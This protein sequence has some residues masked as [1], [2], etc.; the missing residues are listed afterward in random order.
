MM[1]GAVC[2]TSGNETVE[3]VDDLSVEDPGPGEVRVKIHS[4]G[5]CHSD[6][7]GMNGNLPQGAP[8]VPGHEGAGEVVAVGEGVTSTKVGDH[9]IVAWTPPCGKCAAC[10][11]GQPNLCVDI[12]FAIAGVPHFKRAGDDVFG[13]AGTG[14]WVEELI[15][16]EQ[17]VVV[18]PDDVPYE[19]GALIGCGVTTGVGA[20]VNTAQVAVGASV[21]VFGCGG[22]GISAIQGARV[23]GAAEIVAVDTVPD[24][25][26]DAKRFGATHGVHPDDLAAVKVEVTGGGGFDYAFE[27]IGIAPTFRAAWDAT[28]RGGTTVIVGAGR[29]DAILELNGFEL[30]FTEKRLLGSYYGGADVRTE[31][32]R[33]I[34]LW[35]AGR[36]DLEGMVSNRFGL[37]G[38]NA[39][40]EALKKGEVIRQIVNL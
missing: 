24:K 3:I 8:F 4:A 31:F 11:R 37:E 9:V 35:R 40:I 38:I 28:R 33:L 21:V 26:K 25:L 17:G 12:F 7:S 2:T 1:R 34:R 23:C 30:F 13:F 15:L 29:T 14:T 10:L 22:V 6:L 19:I 36:L 16:P 5:I 20:A 32:H 18:I 39:G 27:C